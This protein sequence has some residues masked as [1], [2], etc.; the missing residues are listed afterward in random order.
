MSRA[1]IRNLLLGNVGTVRHRHLVLYNLSKIF[2]SLVFVVVLSG[3]FSAQVRRSAVQ[4]GL[5]WAKSASQVRS[6]L[7]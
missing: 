7:I 3:N 2:V 5:R 4:Y 1:K 6:E